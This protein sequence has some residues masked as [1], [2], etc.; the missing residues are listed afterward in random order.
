VSVQVKLNGEPRELP[1]GASL[2]EAVA[3]LTDLASGVAA[4]APRGTTSPLTAAATPLARSVS[5]ATAS[6]SLAPSGSSRG[7]PLSLT[8]RL[9]A[10][11]PAR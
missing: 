6:A 9:T 10:T 11:R 8:R 1:D 2:A 4:Q 7:S 3:E 5:S